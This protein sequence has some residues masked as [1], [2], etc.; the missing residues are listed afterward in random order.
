MRLHN[1]LGERFEIGS[2]SLFPLDLLITTAFEIV[3]C[4]ALLLV[5]DATVVG[6]QWLAN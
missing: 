3:L 4:S 5:L 1:E 2:S 6:R